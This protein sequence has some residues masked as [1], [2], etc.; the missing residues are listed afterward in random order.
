MYKIYFRSSKG[1]DSI[2]VNAKNR[3]EAFV[4]ALTRVQ[5]SIVNIVSC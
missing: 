3:G 4:I 5:G 2:F 1:I